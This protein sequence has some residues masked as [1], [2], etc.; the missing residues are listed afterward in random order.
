MVGGMG[1]R[2][3]RAGYD[4]VC[5]FQEI[6]GVQGIYQLFSD[7]ASMKLHHESRTEISN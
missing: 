2:T 3:E 4:G 6:G 5:I 1:F 7:I